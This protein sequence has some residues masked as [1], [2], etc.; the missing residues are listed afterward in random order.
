[1]AKEK[2]LEDI[3]KEA[4]EHGMFNKGNLFTA[5]F[6]ST[7]DKNKEKEQENKKWILKIF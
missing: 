2:T 1:M 6:P 5:Q 3:L 4:R 7:D